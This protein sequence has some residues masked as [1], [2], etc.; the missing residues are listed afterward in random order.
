VVKEKSE[1]NEEAIAA[2]G[3]SCVGMFEFVFKIPA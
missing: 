2:S 1:R 3:E